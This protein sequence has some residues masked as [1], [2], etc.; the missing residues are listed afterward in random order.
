MRMTG[1]YLQPEPL[2]KHAGAGWGGGGPAEPRGELQ[3]GSAL[4]VAARGTPMASAVS[5]CC[6]WGGGD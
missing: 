2:C 1:Q 3:V 4:S 5:V 6:V